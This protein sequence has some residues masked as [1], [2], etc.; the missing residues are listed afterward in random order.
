MSFPDIAQI[1]NKKFDDH[2]IDKLS[3]K[4]RTVCP[5]QKIWRELTPIIQVFFSSN[6][7]FHW[8]PSLPIRRWVYWSVRPNWRYFEWQGGLQ[9]NLR[10]K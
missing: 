7:H 9:E 2:L 8:P 10:E 5:S 1:D 6:V 3:S 4:C